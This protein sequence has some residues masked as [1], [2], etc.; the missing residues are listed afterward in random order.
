[1]NPLLNRLIPTICVAVLMSAIPAN[2]EVHFDTS[3]TF[4]V[5]GFVSVPQGFQPA[6]VSVEVMQSGLYDTTDEQ[7]WF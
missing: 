4:L 3:A 1:M 2:A 5:T 7:G 6:G